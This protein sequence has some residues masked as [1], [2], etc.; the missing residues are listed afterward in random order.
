MS[1]LPR[2]ATGGVIRNSVSTHT[3]ART[4]RS[5]RSS[6]AQHAAFTIANGVP[7][8]FCTSPQRGTNENTNGLPRQYLP[9]TLDGP[10]AP[11]PNPITSQQNSTGGLD[12]RSAGRHHHKH[13]TKCCD[14]HLNSQPF[15]ARDS[16]RLTSWM[17]GSRSADADA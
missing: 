8:S 10:N 11:K 13:S 16:V 5:Q 7:S 2:L 15:G 6:T 9:A 3:N 4:E 14:D 17:S 1:G 12:K